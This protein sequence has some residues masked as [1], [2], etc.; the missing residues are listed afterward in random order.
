MPLKST[1]IDLVRGA[2]H[3][4]NTGSSRSTTCS[5]V[6]QLKVGRVRNKEKSCRPKPTSMVKEG[7]TEKHPSGDTQIV[8]TTVASV[9]ALVMKLDSLHVVKLAPA[10]VWLVS[11]VGHTGGGEHDRW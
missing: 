2:V 3:A 10:F 1:R 8:P 6:K 11:S 7:E 5:R 9:V 4:G